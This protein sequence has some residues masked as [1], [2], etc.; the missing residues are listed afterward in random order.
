[1]RVAQGRGD[2]AAG[3]HTAAPEVASDM[4]FDHSVVGPEGSLV[5]LGWVSC[6]GAG[7][8]SA[9]IADVG[10]CWAGCVAGCVAS[11]EEAVGK[12]SGP[13]VIAAG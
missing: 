8:I 4:G 10:R 6:R 13:A 9:G 1:M 11:C 12:R 3:Q 2:S 7:L 5:A